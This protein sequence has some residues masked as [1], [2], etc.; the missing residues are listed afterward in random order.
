MNFIMK[1]ILVFFVFVS[2]CFSNEAKEAFQE[3]IAQATY[4]ATSHDHQLRYTHFKSPMDGT[5]DTV[6]FVQGRGTFLEFY[7][8]VVVPLLERGLDVWMYDLSGQGGSTR[9]VNSQRHDE[10]TAQQM[11]HI[12][13]FDHY[14]ED[15]SSFVDDIVLP[16]A[17][18]RLFLGA[19]STGG[20]VALRY[21]QKKSSE[22]PFQASFLIS[23]LL[24]INLPLSNIS[25]SYLLWGASWFSNLESYVPEAGHEDPVF[26]MPFEGNPYTSDEVGFDQLK[27]L[28]ISH[29]PFMMGGVSY[30]WVRAATDSISNLWEKNAIKSINIPVLIATGGDDGVVDVSYN[31]QFVDQLSKGRHLYYEKG[32][33]ELF[34]E[35]E[36][37]KAL[38][39]AELDQFLFSNVF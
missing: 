13:T 25:M 31:K 1:C 12:D 2:S 9:L 21:L 27:Q 18:G 36:E 35:S 17:Q 20:H 28:C 26:N 19:Y 33:H 6:V 30:G 38:F 23:P 5:K 22:N 8:V 24:A 16:Q 10:I 34:R 39:W 4:Y 7:E 11:Q 3:G 15:L 29:K 14:V 37:L 32:R